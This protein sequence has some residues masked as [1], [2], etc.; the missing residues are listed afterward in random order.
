M[1]KYY[2]LLEE[3]L[4]GYAASEIRKKSR[5]VRDLREDIATLKRTEQNCR[6]VILDLTKPPKPPRLPGIWTK[7]QTRVPRAGREHTPFRIRQ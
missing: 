1:D 6:K 5:T 7:A 4:I 3:M 2:A